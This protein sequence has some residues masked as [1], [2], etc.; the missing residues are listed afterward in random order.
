MQ[1]RIRE[2]TNLA[3]I[4]EYHAHVYFDE[5]SVDQASRLCERAK[6]CFSVEMGRVHQRPVG[7]HP[8]WSCQLKFG[9]E[10]FG[11]LIPWL[12]LN[13]DGLVIFIHPITSDVVKDHIEHAIWMGQIMTLN[14]AA[15][16]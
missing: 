16:K 4:S 1:M 9:E 13:R 5:S 12:A 10:T 11:K 8:M 6:E 7:P 2:G 14:I 15:L 3:T